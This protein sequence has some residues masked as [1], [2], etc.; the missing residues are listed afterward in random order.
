MCQRS[1]FYS[2]GVSQVGVIEG[3]IIPQTNS[4]I[5]LQCGWLGCHG[6]HVAHSCSGHG[7]RCDVCWREHARF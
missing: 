1:R 5:I 6:V 3:V 7:R 4:K 2:G